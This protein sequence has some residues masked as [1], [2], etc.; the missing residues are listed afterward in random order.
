M[1]ISAAE[2]NILSYIEKNEA[3]MTD[4]LRKLV[5]CNSE[6]PPGNETDTA[7]II[8]K[9]LEEIGM[10]TQL[11]E[12]APGRYNIIGIL[13]GDSPETLL[14]NGHMDTVKIGTPENWTCD[15]LGAEIKDDML[16]GRGSCDMKGGLVSMIYALKAVASINIDRKK[17]IMFTGVID[18]EVFFKGTQKLI[19]SGILSECSAC[20]IAEPTSC[21]IATSLQGAAEFTAVT[22]GKSAHCGMA[23]MGVN[24][25][26]PMSDFIISLKNEGDILKKKYTAAGSPIAPTINVGLIKGG[27]D[28]LLVP[29]RCE[30]SF[31][32]Q[33][34]PDENMDEAIQKIR[35]LFDD[36]C[37]KHGVKGEI[38]CNQYFFPWKCDSDHPVIKAAEASHLKASG[39]PSRKIVFRG[40][41]EIEMLA[42]YGIPGALYGPG[43]ILQAH[44]PDEFVSLS[45][46]TQAAKT[47]ALTAYDFIK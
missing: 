2:Q 29:D 14:F 8:K 41:A 40:Y 22:Y 33:V 35:S 25:I 32:R 42:R 46:V 13:E 37:R 20:Y 45:E 27:T 9:K 19:D 47:Y 24:A 43:S 4:F 28:I 5:M 1:D 44:R 7:L 11:Q 34:F 16:Y 12:A 30:I 6:N 23:E 17:T 31:D 38:N 15:P 26:I 10:R 36:V 39:D 21:G 18:E 3:E